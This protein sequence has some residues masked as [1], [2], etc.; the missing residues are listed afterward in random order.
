M[1]FGM[2]ANLKELSSVDMRVTV[3]SSSVESCSSVHNLNVNPD[4]QMTKKEDVAQ[5]AKICFQGIQQLRG[6]GLEQQLSAGL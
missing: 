2:A 1:W 3:G 4:C 6:I 5:N